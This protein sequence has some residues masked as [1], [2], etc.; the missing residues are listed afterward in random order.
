M[1]NNFL[2]FFWNIKMQFL[3]AVFA[4]LF[5]QKPILAQQI[6]ESSKIVF[7]QDDINTFKVLMQKSYATFKQINLPTDVQIAL[8]QFYASHQITEPQIGKMNTQVFGVFNTIN[9][10]EER[11]FICDFILFSRQDQ[12]AYFPIEI[13]RLERNK[14]FEQLKKTKND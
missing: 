13:L 4:F 6:T 3:L 7:S 2:K 11:I 14:M 10:L 8:E 9:S 1:K 5:L 12:Q